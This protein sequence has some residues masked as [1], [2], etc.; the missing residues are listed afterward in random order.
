MPGIA[1]ESDRPPR[2]QPAPRE[3]DAFAVRRWRVDSALVV[4][5]S[6]DIDLATAGQVR[7][8]ATDATA[9]RL[10]LDL[11]GVAFMDTSGVRLV[12]EL[13]QVQETGGPALWVVANQPPVLRLLEMAGLVSR[14]R[15][16]AAVDEA[17]R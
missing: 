1:Q 4:S 5:V 12:V 15:L 11:R 17:L 3:G 16:A 10:V 6:G 8:A 13:L 9:E 2:E 14:L 7:D